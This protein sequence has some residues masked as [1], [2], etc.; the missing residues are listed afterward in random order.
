MFGGDATCPTPA[1]WRCGV[2][3]GCCSCSDPAAAHAV[4]SS[5]SL[6]HRTQHLPGAE[7]STVPKR[8]K[9]AQIW[10]APLHTAPMQALYLSHTGLNSCSAPWTV[11]TSRRL[12]GVS[13][14][15]QASTSVWEALGDALQCCTT[16]APQSIFPPRASF[17]SLSTSLLHFAAAFHGPHGQCTWLGHISWGTD[18][19]IRIW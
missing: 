15:M 14:R 19:S 6:M 12:F 16:P 10:T 1:G 2:P 4:P 9:P 11:F 17:P 3:P 18:S 5:R 13:P 7:L 8:S